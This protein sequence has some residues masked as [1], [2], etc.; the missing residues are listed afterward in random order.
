M[1]TRRDRDMH[2]SMVLDQGQETPIAFLQR[3]IPFLLQVEVS[4]QTE[5]VPGEFENGTARHK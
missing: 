4:M 3:N 2:L 1:R 5:Y